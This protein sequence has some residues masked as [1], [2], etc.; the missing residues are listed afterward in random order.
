MA[1]VEKIP[2]PSKRTATL[3]IDDKSISLPVYDGAEGPSVMDISKL[4]AET[5]MFTYDPGF[6]STASC[7]S[8]ITYI[9]GEAGILRHRGYSIQDLAEKSTYLETSYLLI[10]GELPDQNQYSEFVKNIKNNMMVHE[11]LHILYRGFPRRSHP[12]AI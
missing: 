4:Y 8:K 9:D 7:E 3:T 6:M 10:N 1:V 11:Q 12:M 2:S 5:G